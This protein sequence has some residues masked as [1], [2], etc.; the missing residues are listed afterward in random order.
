MGFVG[1]VREFRV[2]EVFEEDGHTKEESA[3]GFDWFGVCWFWD[4][5][6]GIGEETGESYFC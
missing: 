3:S 6:G 5:E 2:V 1:L 4:V